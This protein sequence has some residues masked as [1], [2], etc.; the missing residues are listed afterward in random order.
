MLVALN[1]KASQGLNFRLTNHAG[2][3]G[4]EELLGGEELISPKTRTVVTQN[5]ATH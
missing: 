1:L 4:T 5:F 3:L 2:F